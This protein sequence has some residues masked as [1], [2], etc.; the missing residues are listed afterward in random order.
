MGDLRRRWFPTEAEQL[1]DQ[2]QSDDEFQAIREHQ[3]L[4][5]EWVTAKG[6][7]EFKRWLE[8]QIERHDNP[9]ADPSQLLIDS[10]IRSGLRMVMK[11]LSFLATGADA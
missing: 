8:S 5:R 7:V 1:E 10:G 11:Q 2:A 6:A 3:A 4:L 9:S